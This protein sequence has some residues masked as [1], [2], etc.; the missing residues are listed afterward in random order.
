[1]RSASQKSMEWK[2][3]AC[4]NCQSGPFGRIVQFVIWKRVSISTTQQRVAC[5]H[6]RKHVAVRDRDSMIGTRASVIWRQN[7]GEGTVLWAVLAWLMAIGPWSG[8][9]SDTAHTL[10]HLH[11]ADLYPYRRLVVV[12]T[13]R[14]TKLVKWE[15]RMLPHLMVCRCTVVDGAVGGKCSTRRLNAMIAWWV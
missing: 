11:T 7:G 3:D 13:N 12:C 1:M 2:G 4:A 6:V 14:M 15:M 9:P 10:F 8:M 5:V